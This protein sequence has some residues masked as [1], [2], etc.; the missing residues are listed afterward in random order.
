MKLKYF[1]SFFALIGL[2]AS[3]SDDDSITL[4]DDVQVSA[5]TVA[6]DMAGGET[7]ITVNAKS[8]WAFN[9]VIRQITKRADGS[10]DTTYTET[11]DW[12]TVSPL[13]GGAGE[14]KVTFSAP[15]TDDG[16]SVELR[17]SCN[18]NTQIINVIQGLP[19]VTEATCAQVIAGPESKT[20][21]VTG[22]VTRIANTEYGNWYLKDET[23]EIYIYGTLDKDGKNGKNN[24]IQA[25]NIEAG[26][27]ITV[28]GP[29]TVY[30][31][32][33]ELVD[34]AVVKLQKWMVQV[35]TVY[36]AEKNVIPIEGG[37][38]TIPL[39]SKSSTGI[40]VEIPDADKDWLSM[41]AITGGKNPTVTFHAM[42][43]PKGDRTS[44]VMF[45][46]TDDKGVVYSAE[47][48]IK[49]AG[50]I[51]ECT[52]ADFLDAA[53]DET[54][55][56]I[57]GIVTDLYR[58]NQGFYLRDYTGQTLIYTP[59]G[60]TGSEV[61]AGDIVTVV[62][63]RSSY[64]GS[65]QMKSGTIEDVKVATPISIADFI[66]LPDDLNTY[67]I[68]SGKIIDAYDPT[69]N[70]VTKF[71]NFNLKD[72]TGDVFVY[73]VYT[74]WG[75]QKGHFGELNLTWGDQLTIVAY[76]TTYKGLIEAVGYYLSSEKQ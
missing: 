13:S 24:S 71:G 51:V 26:D 67:Y 2:L 70:D 21:R 22:T 76:K 41:Q 37:N 54:Q 46:T 49:Q 11:P 5:S 50:S 7:T 68:I 23:G 62:G 1:L 18:G 47:A 16:R 55:Y 57:Q 75:G 39:V 6:I 31:G 40:W 61:K 25:W 56:K 27:L 69:K 63:Q 8:D 48:T 60:F 36:H 17:L 20:Y 42:A 43:N 74:G 45:K 53:E 15:A 72:E 59:A 4:L 65:P 34:V 33:V 64:K 3:C 9:K 58:T 14:T 19:V 35:D 28:E 30:N 38:V 44:R 12:L 29:K 66:N 10:N 32:T 73:G 52:V